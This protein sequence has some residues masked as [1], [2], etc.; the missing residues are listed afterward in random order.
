MTIAKSVLR[1]GTGNN[2]L[3]YFSEMYPG[4][5]VVYNHFLDTTSTTAYFIGATGH[6]IT[7]FER[8]ALSTTLVDWTVSAAANDVNAYKYLM[9]AREEVDS[10]EY[11][12]VVGST[13]V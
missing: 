3:N 9:N 8:E 10:I 12:G 5:K 4:M 7:R 6:G 2:D 11:S 13:G 1:A